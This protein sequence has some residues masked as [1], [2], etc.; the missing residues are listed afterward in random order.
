MT[1]QKGGHLCLIRKVQTSLGEKHLGIFLSKK[2]RILVRNDTH[3]N[4]SQHNDNRY[5]D[6]HC[7]AYEYANTQHKDTQFNHA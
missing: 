6:T 2:E 3:H 5:T 7:N 4:D 1:K